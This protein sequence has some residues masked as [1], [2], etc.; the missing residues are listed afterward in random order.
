MKKFQVLLLLLLAI[1]GVKAQEITSADQ[2]ANKSFA[3]KLV[4]KKVIIEDDDFHIWG[5]SP[6]WGNDGR[7]HVFTSRMP[8]EDNKQTQ[9]GFNHWYATSEIAHYVADQVEG[10][11]EYVKTLLKPGQAK[12]GAWNTGAQHNPFITK[13]DDVFVL[14]YVSNAS[15]I[16]NRNASSFRIGMMKTKDLNGSWED[17]GYVL[18]APAEDDTLAWSYPLRAAGRGVDNP[19]L[20]HH[21]NGK[22]YLYYRVKWKGLEG[23]NTYVVAIA[24]K[25]EGP[26]IHGQKRLINNI[27]YIEDP[28]VFM[29]G[30]TVCMLVTDNYRNK[31][32]LL[33]SKD[34]L[35]FDFEQAE[36]G[37]HVMEQYI[38]K[39][40]VEQA[41]NYRHPKFERPQLL[42]K[43]GKPTH[44]FAPGGCNINNGPG[45]CCYLLEI[46]E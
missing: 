19:T 1:V 6:I 9:Y 35:S 18:S 30:N 3:D 25:L 8:I 14:L 23:D 40:I 15:T 31:G 44:L 37:F 20:L 4:F 26:Y 43:D 38:D 39:N 27:R 10:P 32:L 13:I 17:C 45:T 42:I 11:Y 12:E 24:D 2:K 33:R 36:E 16:S 5:A 22:F 7:I 34:G 29:E 46:V 41:A 21:P 28:Y